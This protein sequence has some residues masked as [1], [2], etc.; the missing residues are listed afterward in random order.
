[1]SESILV[2]CEVLCTCELFLYVAK[3]GWNKRAGEGRGRRR[4]LASAGRLEPGLHAWGR[5]CASLGL[6]RQAGLV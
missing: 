5:R 4:A 3:R 1:M 6:R 2:N